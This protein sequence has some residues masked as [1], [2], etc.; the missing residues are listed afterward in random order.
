MFIVVG[1][2]TSVAVAKHIAGELYGRPGT[3]LIRRLSIPSS[4]GNLGYST[5]NSKEESEIR[6]V[7]NDPIRISCKE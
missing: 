6:L 5:Y 4:S 7:A 3:G 2:I 1:P